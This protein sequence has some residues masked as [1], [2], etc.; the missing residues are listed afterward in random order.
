MTIVFRT[1]SFLLVVVL[2]L[3][4]GL[5]FV[6]TN[7]EQRAEFLHFL[8]QLDRLVDESL[9]SREDLEETS[10]SLVE[11]AL[12]LARIASQEIRWG[13]QVLRGFGVSAWNSVF[14]GA[15][16]GRHPRSHGNPG[17]GLARL[18]KAEMPPYP[19]SNQRTWPYTGQYRT[20]GLETQC[21][22]E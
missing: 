13:L 16:R 6:E 1:S 18:F 15:G 19:W 10:V 7:H 14:G 22:K 3:K 9:R 17:K 20:E 8:Q 4:V 2:S 11:M 12:G 21:E 5:S